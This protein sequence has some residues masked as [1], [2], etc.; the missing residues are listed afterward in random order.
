MDNVY[1]YI[2]S[3]VIAVFHIGVLGTIS[4][5]ELCTNMTCPKMSMC[6]TNTTMQRDGKFLIKIVLLNQLNDAD[7]E[8]I[9]S[10]Y[11]SI[12]NEI[13]FLLLFFSE[14]IFRLIFANFA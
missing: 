3:L 8:T 2:V 10:I 6:F 5:Q 13:V 1:K 7:I 14:L 12:N 9:F 4:W 11:K